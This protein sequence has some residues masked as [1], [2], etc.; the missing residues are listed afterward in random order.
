VAPGPSGVS[1]R[2]RL[3]LTGDEERVLRAVGGQLGGLASGDVARRCRDGLRH[4]NDT[5]AARKRELTS[6]SSSR[7]AGSITKATHDQWALARRGQAA[8]LKGLDA[9][10]ATLTHRLSQPVGAK[11]TKRAPGGYRSAGEW[12]AKSRRLAALQDR[13]ATLAADSAAAG[14]GWCAAA[15][16]SPTPATTWST[17]AR[18]RPRRRRPCRGTGRW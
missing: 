16:S 10:I 3:R 7:W 2:T 1:V 6:A 4:G 12:H 14:S 8:H 18:R 9:G 13:R 17:G 15:R 11:G 5:W